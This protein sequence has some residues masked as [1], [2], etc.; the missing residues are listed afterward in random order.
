MRWLASSQNHYV[1][2]MVVWDEVDS[3]FEPCM[4]SAMVM[5]LV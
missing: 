2:Y 1:G 4:T 5:M 3:A